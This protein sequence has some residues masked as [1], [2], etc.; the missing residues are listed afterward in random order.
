MK[1]L[2]STWDHLCETPIALSLSLLAIVPF[3]FPGLES[4]LE[5]QFAD[6]SLSNAQVVVGC[7]WLHW[8]ASH[9]FWD[10]LMFYVVGRLCELSDRKAFI[11]VILLSAP[12]IPL[13]ILIACPQL[14]SYR[15]LS[16]IDTALFALLG[17]SRLQESIRKQDYIGFLVYGLLLVAMFLK[18][19]YETITGDVLFA[20][21]STFT[22]VAL[23]HLTGSL[24]GIG[25]ALTTAVSGSIVETT[26][27]LKTLCTP[28][29]RCRNRAA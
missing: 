17:T 4:F 25:V 15:G 12:L 18:I 24:V 11:S 7:N 29:M 1:P 16:G 22:P 19:L 6:S 3:V 13:A 10:L 23:A 21:K 9:L 2:K 5:F 27:W 28:R 14:G 20:D 8:S 26:V